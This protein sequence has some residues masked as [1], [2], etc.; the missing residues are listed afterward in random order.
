MKREC[1]LNNEQ[2]LT[3][4]RALSNLFLDTEVDDIIIKYIART[5]LESGLVLS[6]VED[7]LWYEVYPVLGN[8]LRSVAG[9]W[10]GW[11]D[12]WLL[13]HLPAPVRPNTIRGNA[14]I[15]K[16]IK[17]CWLKVAEFHAGQNV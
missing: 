9:V 14:F 11:S 17:R 7:I 1:S 13:H 16:E 6:E 5:I 15:I 2:R 10:D 4:W 8:N 3:I 12:S